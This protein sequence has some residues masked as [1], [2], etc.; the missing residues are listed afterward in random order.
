MTRVFILW[1]N[2]YSVGND[3]IDTQHKIFISIINE[4]YESFVDQTTSIK[5]VEII[6]KLI[7][8]SNY[9]F[10]TEEELI[11]KHNYPD[12]E[13]HMA[14]HD[15]F[16]IKMQE[17]RDEVK[18]NKSSLTF[19]LMNYLRNWLLLHLKDEDQQYATFIRLTEKK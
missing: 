7:D 8:Y 10:K 6:D 2:S 1:E 3:T 19:Q 18:S 16:R 5:L 11:V 9:H 17:F 15:A 13:A 12:I 4:L 14:A